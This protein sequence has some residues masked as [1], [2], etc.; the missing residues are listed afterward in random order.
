MKHLTQRRALTLVATG[1]LVTATA[2]GAYAAGTSGGTISACVHHDGGGLYQARHCARDDR[3]LQWSVRGP[4]GSQGAAGAAGPAGP[5]GAPG[6]RGL[7]GP[8]GPQGNGGPKGEQGATG[9][10]GPQGDSFESGLT[11][12]K[13]L[14]GVYEIADTAAAKSVQDQTTAI[15]ETYAAAL[16]AVPQLHLI[17]DGATPPAVCS[18]S[19][20]DPKAAPGNLC[21]YESRNHA[22]LAEDPD[23]FVDPINQA[24]GTL[25]FGIEITANSAGLYDSAGTWAVTAS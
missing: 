11:S 17:A 10:V 22:N 23:V 7:T 21:V 14:R 13:T 15:S 18:G 9:P 2:G 20:A 3:Q 12:G 1:A 5:A 19:V 24:E 16:P 6:P 8:P 25:G 4:G